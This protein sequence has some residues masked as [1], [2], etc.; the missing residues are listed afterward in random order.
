MFAAKNLERSRAPLGVFEHDPVY[1]QI[2]KPTAN[3]Q[4]ADSVGADERIV[5]RVSRTG[6]EQVLGMLRAMFPSPNSVLAGVAKKSEAMPRANT[7]AREAAEVMAWAIWAIV[8]VALLAFV[9]GMTYHF[10]GEYNAKFTELV[11]QQIGTATAAGQVC[12]TLANQKLPMCKTGIQTLETNAR[13][14]AFDHAISHICGDVFICAFVRD[15]F[16]SVFG[17]VVVLLPILFVLLVVSVA[18]FTWKGAV[19]HWA[20]RMYANKLRSG[21]LSFNPDTLQSQ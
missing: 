10:M 2:N 18:S 21:D 8:L 9:G 14:E 15:R 16:K 19:S 12:T 11:E 13:S 4:S 3:L 6:K 7:K 1:P 20:T 17:P 5:F